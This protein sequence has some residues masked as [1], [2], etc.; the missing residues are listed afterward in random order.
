MK[1]RK[2]EIKRK[3][4][5]KWEEVRRMRKRGIKREKKV[6]KRREGKRG[7]GRCI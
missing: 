7:K 4:C 1:G 3:I 2:G 5:R 6:G